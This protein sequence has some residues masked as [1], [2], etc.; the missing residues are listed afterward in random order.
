MDLVYLSGLVTGAAVTL[1]AACFAGQQMA[2]ARRRSRASEAARR[3]L[4][5]WVSMDLRAPLTGLSAMADALG[6]SPQGLHMRSEVD[7]LA[8]LA[9]DLVEISRS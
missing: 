2:A 1:L 6:D 5:S 3:E 7:R 8:H 9:D 4:I